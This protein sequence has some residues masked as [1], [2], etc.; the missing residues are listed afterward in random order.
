[1][2][3]NVIKKDY[4]GMIKKLPVREA[5]EKRQATFLEGTIG[6]WYKNKTRFHTMRRRK[7]SGKLSPALSSDSN[8]KSFQNLRP[9]S[10]THGFCR[11]EANIACPRKRESTNPT[12]YERPNVLAIP[13]SSSPTPFSTTNKS[14]S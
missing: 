14:R 12:L 11:T 2:K 8:T 5:A 7:E 13:K 1:V 4:L 10:P 6:Y 9:S 3:D